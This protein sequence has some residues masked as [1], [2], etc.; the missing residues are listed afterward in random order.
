MANKARPKSSFLEACCS[1]HRLRRG[2][3]DRDSCGEELL[4]RASER[5]D[6]ATNSVCRHV[7]MG[8]P[9]LGTSALVLSTRMHPIMVA[10]PL[11][12][13]VRRSSAILLVV[14]A[15]GLKFEGHEHQTVNTFSHLRGRVSNVADHTRRASDKLCL[16]AGLCMG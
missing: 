12:Q 15:F 16:G 7:P 11:S 5:H 13:R 8:T 10:C 3:T 2:K 14:C 4:S 6:G 9:I 1:E